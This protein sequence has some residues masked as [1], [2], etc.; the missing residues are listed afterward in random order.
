[1]ETAQQ[2]VMAFTHRDAYKPLP[3]YKGAVGH[4]H[5]HFNEQLSDYGSLD[6][7]PPWIPTFRSHGIN[8]AMMSDFHSD[9]HPRDPGPIRLSEQKVYFDASARHSDTDF[10]II[11]A[12]EPNNTLGAHYTMVFTKPVYWTEVRG[13]GQSMVENVAG[14][15]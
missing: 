10:L 9:S 12:E 1:P 14:Y 15:G 6:F 7:E 3:G 13:A 5:T 4:F 11:P 2:S 8:I